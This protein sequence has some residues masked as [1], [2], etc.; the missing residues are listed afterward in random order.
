M[1]IR[2]PYLDQRGLSKGMVPPTPTGTVSHRVRLEA[3]ATRTL[4]GWW[5]KDTDSPR[6]VQ[7]RGG[8]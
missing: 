3:S 5:W 8:D 2:Q 1:K 6:C 4:S 7:M